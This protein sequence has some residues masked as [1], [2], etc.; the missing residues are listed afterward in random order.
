LATAVIHQQRECPSWIRVFS[1][2]PAGFWPGSV[3]DLR[4]AITHYTRDLDSNLDSNLDSKF[5]DRLDVWSRATNLL[6]ALK[7]ISR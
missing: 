6:A 4:I 3:T 7:S 5:R 1:A 2:N